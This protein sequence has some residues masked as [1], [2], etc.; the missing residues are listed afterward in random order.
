MSTEEKIWDLTQ[1][2][3]VKGVW[4]GC[5]HA[6]LAMRQ[7]SDMC[8]HQLCHRCSRRPAISLVEVIKRGKLMF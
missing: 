1:S 7:V 5:K 6:V 3:N 8:Y 2:I 4:Y